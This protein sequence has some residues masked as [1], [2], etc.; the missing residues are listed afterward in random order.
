[1]AILGYPAETK[2]IR[3]EDLDSFTGKNLGDLLQGISQEFS[4]EPAPSGR[5]GA[6]RKRIHPTGGD[7]GSE[8]VLQ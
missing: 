8:R 2:K 5:R 6:G 7:G 4:L 3:R 1:L